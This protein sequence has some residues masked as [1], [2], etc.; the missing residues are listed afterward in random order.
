MEEEEVMSRVH[1]QLSTIQDQKEQLVRDIVRNEALGRDLR[2]RL[3]RGLGRR[4][5]AKVTT[6][7]SEQEKVVLLLLSLTSRLE[8]AE[9]EASWGS[10]TDWQKESRRKTQDALREML[11]EAGGL[12]SLNG[13]RLLQ[14]V[15]MLETV[16]LEKEKM[17]LLTYVSN[18]EAL[19]RVRNTCEHLE[20]RF[21]M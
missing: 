1:R 4:H 14:V 15:E 20:R 3:T 2:V 19:L 21:A 7:L 8:R 5:L 18:K 13:H 10:I 17:L 16:G 12:R 6:F 11:E 9:E